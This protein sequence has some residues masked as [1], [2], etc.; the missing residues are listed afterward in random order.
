M[1]LSS[2]ESGSLSGA[3]H[4]SFSST[5]VRGAMALS[6][7]AFRCPLTNILMAQVSSLQVNDTGVYDKN[8][9]QIRV[10]DIVLIDGSEQYP[11]SPDSERVG[12]FI[13]ERELG[14]WGYE[15]SWKHLSGYPCSTH[16]MGAEEPGEWMRNVEIVGHSNE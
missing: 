5:A 6:G 10:G 16:I 12:R 11:D 13:V 14:S 15:Y 7:S 8:G 4:D 3:A 1:S 2:I 9:K